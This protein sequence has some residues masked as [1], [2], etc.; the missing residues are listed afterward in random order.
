[1]SSN[2]TMSSVALRTRSHDNLSSINCD[3]YEKKMKKQ[4]NTQPTRTHPMLLRN[5]NF[6]KPV[7]SY[8]NRRNTDY[9]YDDFD[10]DDSSNEWRRNKIAQRNGTFVYA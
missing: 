2:K 3:N 6:H 7:V 1:M 5:W 4:T 8:S 10:F 9:V